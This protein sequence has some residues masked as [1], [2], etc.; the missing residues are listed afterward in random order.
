MPTIILID[1]QKQYIKV[2]YICEGE[3]RPT[4]IIFNQIE[5]T[6]CNSNAVTNIIDTIVIHCWI[7]DGP[8]ILTIWGDHGE[9]IVSGLLDSFGDCFFEICPASSLVIFQ[10]SLIENNILRDNDNEFRIRD[11]KLLEYR[12][13]KYHTLYGVSNC[14]IFDHLAERLKKIS[15][16][17]KDSLAISNLFDASMQLHKNIRTSYDVS[18]EVMRS[19]VN[20]TLGSQEIEDECKILKELGRSMDSAVNFCTRY[21]FKM[22]ALSLY[23]SEMESKYFNDKLATN[24]KKKMLESG[25]KI[26]DIEPNYHLMTRDYVTCHCKKRNNQRY[27]ERHNK[28][29]LKCVHCPNMTFKGE[30]QLDK[31]LQLHMDEIEINIWVN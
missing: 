8:N 28:K 24:I 5:D 23:Y 11:D 18:G 21:N 30:F 17:F 12:L 22:P 19:L 29:F 31:H 6:L 3:K 10:I 14:K 25:K 2:S 4:C 26:I 7:F 20:L 16:N 27:C 1:I 15:E 9:D 13:A